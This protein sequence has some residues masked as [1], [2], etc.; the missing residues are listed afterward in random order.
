MKEVGINKRAYK[1]L[2]LGDQITEK[3]IEYLEKGL[4]TYLDGTDQN[5]CMFYRIINS[6][7]DKENLVSFLIDRLIVDALRTT[8]NSNSRRDPE[9]FINLKKIAKVFLNHS[10]DDFYS[11]MYIKLSK[12]FEILNEIDSNEIDIEI[13]ESSEESD[14]DNMTYKVV[15]R[16]SNIN[17]NLADEFNNI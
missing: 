14:S 7:A 15:N 3:D 9:A 4:R 5:L 6:L 12:A 10:I 16:I 8:M 1:W 17:Y 2:N 13:T 11:S